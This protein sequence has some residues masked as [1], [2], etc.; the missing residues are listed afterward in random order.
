MNRSKVRLSALSAL[1]A[2]IW[3]V[4]TP[5]WA[6]API[7]N[8]WDSFT[9]SVLDT[10][11]GEIFDNSGKVHALVTSQGFSHNNLHYVGIGESSG[12]SYVADTT[13]NAPLHPS[14]GGTLTADFMVNLIVVSTASAPN[15]RLTF[16]DQQIFDSNGNLISET[17]K[18][19][20]SCPG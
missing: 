6:A 19:S 12:G 17:I 7:E 10:C 2:A 15:L 11:T 18:F 16:S 20:S 8:G 1:I 14:A 3:L 13:I 4:P 5:V 9:G